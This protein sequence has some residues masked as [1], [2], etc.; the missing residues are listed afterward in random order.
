MIITCDHCGTMYD[1]PDEDIQKK[2]SLENF[3]CPACSTGTEATL[4]RGDGGN[5][6][7]PRSGCEHDAGELLK[8]RILRTVADLPPMPQVARKA[9]QLIADDRSSFRDLAQIIE[10]DQAIAARV[11]KVSNSS[12]YGMV[13][14]ITS[15]QQAAVMLGTKTLNE[16]LTFACAD[17]LLERE[18]AGY[19]LS[20]GDLWRH[21]LAVAGC[22][23]SIAAKVQPSLADDAFSTGLIHD[24]GKLILNGPIAER[25]S[26]FEAFLSPEGTSFLRAEKEIL[27]FD[28]AEIAAEICTKWQIPDK[29]TRAIRAH[30]QPSRAGGDPLAYIVHAADAIVLMSGIGS[31][32]DGLK[33]EI[34]AEVMQSLNL[35]SSNIG[36]H[37][38]EALEF[39]EQTAGMY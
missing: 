4:K 27:G 29:M 24:C 19:G 12:Y 7:T 6:S 10:T 32:I 11:L 38:A 17:S 2:D 23:R 9:W 21:S 22:A 31:G 16:I 26:R 15:I 3:L 35:N 14:S 30:H 37:M 39:V 5:E 13:G 28:H 25:R 36:L 18:L 8:Q 20:S 34:D 33:Y 1:I